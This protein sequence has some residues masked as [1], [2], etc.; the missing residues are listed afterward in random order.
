MAT[1]MRVDIDVRLMIPHEQVLNSGF[2]DVMR[3]AS[4][5]PDGTVQ[6]DHETFGSGFERGT[7]IGQWKLVKSDE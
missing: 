7:V 6:L 5:Q 1:A 4:L 2:A 3:E